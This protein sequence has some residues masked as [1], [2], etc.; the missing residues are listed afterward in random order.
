MLAAVGFNR[1]NKDY[2]SRDPS[3]FDDPLVV[4]VFHHYLTQA[5]PFGTMTEYPGEYDGRHNGREE[6]LPVPPA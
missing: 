4:G 6:L 3:I 5:H 2:D 1:W